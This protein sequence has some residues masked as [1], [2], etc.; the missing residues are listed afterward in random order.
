MKLFVALFVMAA[1]PTF[2]LAQEKPKKEV[3]VTIPKM[4]EAELEVVSIMEDS[5]RM[6]LITT[7]KIVKKDTYFPHDLTGGEVLFVQFMMGVKATTYAKRDYPGL[8]VG[9]R[10]WAQLTAVEQ[11]N[12]KPR[13]MILDY[14]YLPSK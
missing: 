2:L 5:T 9:K 1:S 12:G 7:Y 6:A 8:E 13:W 11:A 10:Y 14:R 3:T 4:V